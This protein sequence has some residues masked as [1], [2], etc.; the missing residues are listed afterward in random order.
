MKEKNLEKV[1][2]IAIPLI[3]AVLSFFV[4]SKYV[5]APE[6]HAETIA[7]LEEKR[8]DV[9]ELT[10]ASTVAST[11]L[12]T[13]PNDIGTPVANKLADLSGYFLIALCALFLEKYLLTISGY[14]AFKWLIPIACIIFSGNVGLKNATLKSIAGKL[15]IFSVAIVMVVPTSVE[16][17]KIIESTHEASIEDALEVV[18][19]IPTEGDE[20]QTEEEANNPEEDGTEE[21]GLLA[22]V[23]TSIGQGAEKITTAAKESVE[24][25]V[26]GSEK[27]LNYAESVLSNFIEALAVILVTSCI[28]PVL[29]LLFFAW[30]IKMVLESNFSIR[31]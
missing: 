14:V 2:R 11:V 9:M 28:I 23:F 5:T 29:V 25:V 17:S 19:N 27:L 30:I 15:V 18:K 12:S 20:T 24:N 13:L 4:V 16:I 1:L 31:R 10:A 22:K 6:F 3:I 26:T 21:K 8:D 7:Y